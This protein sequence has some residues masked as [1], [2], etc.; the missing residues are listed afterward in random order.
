M[1]SRLL[2]RLDVAIAQA[3]EPTRNACLRAERTLALARLGRLDEARRG[4]DELQSRFSLR[5]QAAVSAW[6]AL[7]QGVIEHV[8]ARTAAARVPLQRA[9]AL[10]GASGLEALHALASA[11]LA[12]VELVQHDMAAMANRLGD[13]LRRAAVDDHAARSRAALVAAL[14]YHLAGRVDRARPWYEQARQHALADADDATLAELIFERALLQADNAR[15]AIAAGGDPAGF[16]Q[17]LR[18]AA[19]GA[20]SAVALEAATGGHLLPARAALLKAQALTA[21]GRCEAALAASESHRSGASAP[22]RPSLRA[23][24]AW[25]ESSLGRAEPA[26]RTLAAALAAL[27]TPC[28]SADRAC[29]QSRL[30][31]LLASLA[32]PAQAQQLRDRAQRDLASHR[33]E[34]QRLAALL[35]DTLPAP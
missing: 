9:H 7:A 21:A 25:C 18:E 24:L 32:Q 14:G 34:Q 8:A 19:M 22:L 27:D 31:D 26:R 2:A 15:L 13:A 12:Q 23:D 17:E 1:A 35:D 30:A 6:L 10:S 33:A 20:D 5:P 16:A 28:D 3:R 29:A 11:W 4:V